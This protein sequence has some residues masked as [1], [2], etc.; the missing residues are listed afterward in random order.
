MDKSLLLIKNGP[1]V[2]VPTLSR[3]TGIPQQR[4]KTLVHNVYGAGS[5]YVKA[6]NR[7]NDDSH[8]FSAL[9]TVCC[10]RRN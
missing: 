4:L 5:P 9:D 1:R 8:N 7:R 2:H 3:A 6:K 10:S